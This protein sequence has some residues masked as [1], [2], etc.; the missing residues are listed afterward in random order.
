MKLRA[1][2][3]ALALLLAL[4]LAACGGKGAAE[5]RAAFEPTPRP[6]T[7]D[8][9]VIKRTAE[10]EAEIEAALAAQP[11]DA[12]RL[13]DAEGELGFF[14]LAYLEV[15][16]ARPC[17]VNAELAAPDDWRWPYLLGFIGQMR[18]ELDTAAAAY[19]RAAERAPQEVGPRLRLA[20]TRIEQGK[21]AEA[22][23]QLAA[24]LKLSPGLPAALFQEARRL[25]R[26]GD[27][28]NAAP[29]LEKVLAAQPNAGSARHLLGQVYRKLGREEDARKA[30]LAG[31]EERVRFDDP[32]LARLEQ[33]GVSEGFYR[34]RGDRAFEAGSYGEAV[35]AYRRLFAF[36]AGNF[37]DHQRLAYA[38]YLQ[39]DKQAAATELRLARARPDA[40]AAEAGERAEAHRL[41]AIM[42][43]ERGEATAAMLELRDGIAAVPE[44]PAG[45]ETL[46]LMLADTLVKS[47]DSKAALTVYEEW[48][49][50]QPK[51]PR[52]LLERGLLRLQAGQQKEGA[53]DV[54]QAAELAPADADLQ[55]RSGEVFEKLGDREAARRSFAAALRDQ[56][57]PRNPEEAMSRGMALAHLAN[58]ERGAGKTQEAEKLY[59]QAL[60]VLPALELR[61]NLAELLLD[62]GAF[63]E[64]AQYF[65]EA[66]NQDK[67][68]V[69]A[70]SGEAAALI[71]AGRFAEARKALEAGVAE[72]PRAGELRHLLARLLAIAPEA[73]ERQADQALKLALEV[74]QAKGTSQHA[75][76]LAM[77]LAENGR[78]Q[79]AA[80]LLGELLAEGE[81]KKES[82]ALLG[83]WRD[84]L[85]GYQNNRPFRASPPQRFFRPAS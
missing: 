6:G 28:K 67:E 60:Q 49:A 75:E 38:L 59:R 43:L 29:L 71:L 8:P 40:A 82:Q 55:R 45:H 13:A 36:G 32:L 10:L 65:A 70:R 64:A 53:A 31:S 79:E 30:I 51:Q 84:Q 22:A 25:D 73:T 7:E 39:G 21:N 57:P 27:A 19:G 9:A 48:L 26:E 17:F 37:G 15:E 1:L 2:L 3:P 68:N 78:F 47:G 34:L 54:R 63:A 77:A 66:R 44:L 42:L 16:A 69:E 33:V 76:T 11:V 41:A 5:W 24:V 23:E 58:L 35:V 12:K 61:L 4:A 56:A 20:E 18:G 72:L 14:Y 83:Y 50:Q 52:A 74:V 62:R 85:T 80:G 81:K 46:R